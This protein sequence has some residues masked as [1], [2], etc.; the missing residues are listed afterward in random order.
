MPGRDEEQ[1]K[2]E[3]KGFAGLSSLVSDVDTRPP[4]AAKAEPAATAPSTER[5]AQQAPQPQQSQQHQTY[6]ESAQPSSSES[7]GGKWALGIAAV[8]GA[9]WLVGQSDKNATSPD[10]TYSPPR[11]VHC[12][13]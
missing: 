8:I 4:P 1:K 5:P 13:R 2:G 10:P 9:L 11:A 3:G 6:Q 12:S 7:S